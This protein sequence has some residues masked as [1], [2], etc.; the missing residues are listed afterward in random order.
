MKEEG[1]NEN[2]KNRY[3][4]GKMLRE[5]I[6]EGNNSVTAGIIFKTYQLGLDSNV[7]NSQE[8]KERIVFDKR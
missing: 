3:A 2:I 6:F 1:V 5:E 8:W 4:E 7:L